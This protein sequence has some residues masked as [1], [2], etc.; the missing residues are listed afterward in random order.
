MTTG[1]RREFLR[2]TAGAKLVNQRFAYVAVSRGRYDARIYTD[3]K[4]KLA[5][6]LD[7]DVS[8]RSALEGTPGQASRRSEGREI[9]RSESTGHTMAV[10][11]T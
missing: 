4:A 5:A 1:A 3:D 8:H 6:A 11:S 9:S 7:R 10:G 2:G